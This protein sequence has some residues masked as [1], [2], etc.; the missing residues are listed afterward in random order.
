M[1]VRFGAKTGRGWHGMASKLQELG[2]DRN[3]GVA[4]LHF[5]LGESLASSAAFLALPFFAWKLFHR[6]GVFN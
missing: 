6:A 1:S 5:H 3:G 2:C 4:E